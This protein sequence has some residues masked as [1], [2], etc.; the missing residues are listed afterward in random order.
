M[1]ARWKEKTEQRLQELE[2]AL[3]PS[4]GQKTFNGTVAPSFARTIGHRL[5]SLST[6]EHSTN[7]ET[8]TL[9]VTGSLGAF[10]GSSLSDCTPTNDDAGS[11]CLPDLISC[12]IVTVDAA[13]TYFNFYRE[14][15]NPLIHH[16]LRDSTT[17]ADVRGRSAMLT[18]AICTVATLCMGSRDHQACLKAYQNEVSRKLFSTSHSFDDVRA[19]CIGA[20]WQSDISSALNGLGKYHNTTARRIDL[21][22]SALKLFVLAHNSSCTGALRRC[23]IQNKNAT[24]GHAYSSSYIYA[25]ITAPCSTGG[26]R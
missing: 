7:D 21:P 10:P 19:L 17:L 5:G 25:T 13:N 24:I 3:D 16:L 18:A 4:V 26:H 6:A 2:T 20:F 14:H 22:L 23:H 11:A 12:R 15:L 9:N 1:F 8:R